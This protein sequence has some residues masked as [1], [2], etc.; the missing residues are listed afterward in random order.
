MTIRT[1][2]IDDEAPA[3][4]RMKKLLQT[5]KGYELVGEAESGKQAIDIIG[6]QKPDLILL[7]IQLK[8]MT[9]FDVIKSINF[10]EGAIVFIT[11]YD[12]YAIQAFEENAIDYLLKPYK[13]DR[14]YEALNR[15]RERQNVNYEQSINELIRRISD[16]S[17]P[18][19]IRIPEG[20]TTHLVDGRA[21][22]FIQSDGYYS[23]IHFEDGSSKM[24]RISLKS[25]ETILP[26]TFTRI[27]KS[28]IVNRDKILSIR[29]LKRT[30]EI[31]L[32]GNKV[33]YSNRKILGE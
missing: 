11:A 4:R 10:N 22:E 18:L 23:N 30:V 31:E 1:V 28:V 25:L 20:K 2:I 7:D 5:R 13:E 9:G 14:F 32:P 6:L 26:F 15:V 27:N 19:K 8:D 21:I 3:R 24:I 16:T 33:L 12:S 17:S 29:Q